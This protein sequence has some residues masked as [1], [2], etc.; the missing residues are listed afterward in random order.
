[1]KLI[2]LFINESNKQSSPAKRFM[3]DINQTRLGDI[4]VEWEI[5]GRDKV[6]LINFYAWYPG[7]GVGS[8]AME[9]ITKLA[10]KHGVK[11]TL[12][13]DNESEIDKLQRFYERFDFEETNGFLEMIR[14]PQRKSV[15]EDDD[16]L[17][18]PD[19]EVGD[20]VKVGRFKNRKAVVKGFKKDDHN[21]PIIKT[22]KGT[23]KVFTF[24][25]EKLK[26]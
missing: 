4:D 15:F 23:K 20:E 7:Q 25:L 2:E 3:Q 16:V 9:L 24:D 19:I 21:Q 14:Y 6:D 18:L 1:M 11:I 10:D 13:M 17:E 12:I 8:K 26:D 22:S 5:E